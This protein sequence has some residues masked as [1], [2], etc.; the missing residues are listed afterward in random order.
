MFEIESLSS[1][2]CLV[3]QEESSQKKSFDPGYFIMLGDSE[4]LRLLEQRLVRRDVQ[5]EM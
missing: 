5:T 4:V 2:D 1:L 3:S